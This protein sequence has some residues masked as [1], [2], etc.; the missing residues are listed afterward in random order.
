MV[1]L[2]K[3]ME[4]IN[5]EEA[6]HFLRSL[7]QVNS[8]TNKGNEKAVSDVIKHR[9]EGLKLNVNADVISETRE[10]LLVS[11]DYEGEQREQG[12]TLYFSGHFDTV[13]PGNVSWRHPIFNGDIEG[14]RMYGRGTTDMK[15]GVAAMITAIECLAKAD[16]KLNG[17][18]R[19]IGSVGEEVDCFGAKRIV[20]KGQIDDAT[21]IVIGEPTGNNVKIAHKGVLWLKVSVFGKTAHGSMPSLG[22]NAILGMNEFI[23]ALRDYSIQYET[24]AILG[25][26]TLN[27]GMIHGGVGTNVVPDQC[28]MYLDIRTVPGQNHSEIKQDIVQLLENT[29]KD[30]PMSYQLEIIN[31]LGCVHTAPNHEFIKLAENT[32]FALFNNEQQAGGVNYYTDGSVYSQ[33]LPSVPILIYGPGESQNAHQPDEWVDLQKYIDS[34]KFY[35]KLAVKYLS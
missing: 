28:T 3:V 24:D 22:V 17:N 23:N 2:N 35:I 9:L 33:S 32:N 16:V 12:K 30:T 14:N 27:I 4:L 5:E 6:I 21:A 34:I 10:N 31:D 18:I 25:E 7:V 19:F 29:M 13:P 1:D 15:S 8:V 26:S 11:Y 20:E